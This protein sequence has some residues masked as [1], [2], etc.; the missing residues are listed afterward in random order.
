MA[1]TGTGAIITEREAYN[2]GHI[3]LE[4]SSKKA[5]TYGKMADNADS[6]NTDGSIK[7]YGY[8]SGSFLPDKA[9][10]TEAVTPP[11]INR[12]KCVKYADIYNKNVR[13]PWYVKISENVTGGTKA[14]KIELRLY[15][16]T[17]STATET[18]VSCGYWDHGSKIH[19]SA[20]AL[21]Y[22]E[23]NPK[24]LYSGTIYSSRLVIWCG[25]TGGNQ[26]WKWR[27]RSKTGPTTG[28]WESWNKQ[29]N[30]AVNSFA[31]PPGDFL[32]AM[33]HYNGVEFNID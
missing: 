7:N 19:G 11:A 25:K 18:Y 20:S 22:F 8:W 10:S 6:Y 14:H 16:K 13:V 29:S 31:Y 30:N 27:L 4:S 26:T 9:D 1:T 33:K 24:A 32:Y 28:T 5:L 12:Y 2:C 23:A 17:S 15:Y 21:H 3:Y